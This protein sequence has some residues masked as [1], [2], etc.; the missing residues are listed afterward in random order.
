MKENSGS[1]KQL[2]YSL[3]LAPK[4]TL[5]D[6]IYVVQQRLSHENIEVMKRRGRPV[7]GRVTPENAML[8]P[9]ACHKPA[10]KTKFV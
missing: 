8:A 6:G 10:C 3:P 9:S 7:L 2:P 4:S 5:N 1:E